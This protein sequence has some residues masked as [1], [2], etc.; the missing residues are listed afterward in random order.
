M[1][2]VRT[3]VVPYQWA[4]LNDRIENA[5]PSYCMH[6]FQVAAGKKAGKHGGLVFQDSDVAKFLEAVAYV[7]A[8][9]PDS[10]LENIIDAAIDDI[11]AA[12]QPDGYLNTYYILNGLEKRFTNLKDNHELYCLGHFLEAAV[13]YYHTTGKD[14]LLKALIKYVDLVDSLIGA[15][16][17]KTHGYPGHQEIELALIKLYEITQ[18]EK[19]LK[20]AKY[21]I[22]ERGKTPLFFQEETEKQGN[23]FYW[24]HSLFQYGY[25]QA[26]KPVR[27]QQHAVGHSVRALYMYSGM[28]DVAHKTGDE[29]LM[30]ACKRLWSDVTSKQMYITGGVG[31]SHYGEAFTFGY[32]LPND[33]VYAETCASIALAFFARRML[34]YDGFKAEYADV[35]EQT[36]YNGIISGMAA[37]GK[38]FFYVNPLE[39]VPKATQKDQLK[40]HVKTQRQK[41]FGCACCPPNLARIL[42]SLASYAYA[43]NNDTLYINL[44]AESEV[45]SKLQSGTIALN[46]TTRYPWSGTITVK[47]TEISPKSTL[48]MRIPGWCE[49]YSVKIN[50]AAANKKLQNGYLTLTTLKTGDEII[51]DLDMP[52]NIIESNPAVRENIG[53]VAIMRGPIVYCLEEVDNG[54]NLHHIALPA[55]ATFTHHHDKDFYCGAVT[56]Q[57]TAKKLQPTGTQSLYQKSHPPKYTNVT[58]K[59]IPYYLWANRE[60]GEMCC[61]VRVLN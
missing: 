46:I 37:D 28:A 34:E 50:N 40:S 30:N 48:A 47:I 45:K 27:E 22:D 26:H 4:A 43:K 57:T 39:V 10:E 55:N 44:F 5:E 15:E 35:L 42:A 8:W 53:K 1:E 32:D 20:L 11:V 13:A 52:V 18:D 24:Q 49:K 36:L 7:L 23:N 17:G 3:E 21:F 60:P 41:W 19:H 29:T 9:H 12:Q 6:N 14:K 61:W 51:L 16:D 38:S 58:T 56:L 54:D 31:S 59:W 25:Y 2:L 33:T